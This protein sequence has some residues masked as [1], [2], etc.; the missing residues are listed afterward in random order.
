LLIDSLL[1]R[2]VESTYLKLGTPWHFNLLLVALKCVVV[3]QLL[4]SVDFVQMFQ[5]VIIF[6]IPLVSAA[7]VLFLKT[8][9]LGCVADMVEE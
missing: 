6:W 8:A 5:S 4:Q 9:A 3:I 1:T 7:L 2:I